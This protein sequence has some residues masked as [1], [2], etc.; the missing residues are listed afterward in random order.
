LQETLARLRATNAEIV[1][2]DALSFLRTSTQ[3]WDIV[4]LD[5]PFASDV[6]RPVFETLAHNRRQPHAYVYVECS[7]RVALPE[8]PAGWS[9]YRSKRAGE[10][11]YHLLQASHA[12]AEDVS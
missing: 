4:F 1:A 11:G 2:S 7:A 8:L 6:L 5:P 3:S 10:V 12:A 9:V